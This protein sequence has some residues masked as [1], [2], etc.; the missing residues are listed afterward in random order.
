MEN[1]RKRS[2]LE[3]TPGLLKNVDL[4]YGPAID[5]LLGCMLRHF[6][7]L[8][9]IL[10]WIWGITKRSLPLCVF[11]QWLHL[12]K[13]STKLAWCYCDR[14]VNVHRSSI[15]SISFSQASYRKIKV[16]K[17]LLLYLEDQWRQVC[18]ESSWS[19][20]R[21]LFIYYPSALYF[22]LFARIGQLNWII[23]LA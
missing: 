8:D 2:P 17:G 1:L 15:H 22:S 23:P 13:T 5:L 10:R 14:D 12:R 4:G 9:F 18:W 11:E 20:N 16:L 6:K 21:I 3:G 19:N 7:G